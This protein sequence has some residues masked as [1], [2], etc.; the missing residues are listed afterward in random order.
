MHL[1]PAIRPLAPFYARLETGIVMV[2]ATRLWN[3]LRADNALR[4]WLTRIAANR[5]A[6]W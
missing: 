6:L 1:S 5:G 3:R 2:V 4:A